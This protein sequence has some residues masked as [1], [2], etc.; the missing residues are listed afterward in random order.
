[1]LFVFVCIACQCLLPSQS[2]AG[3]NADAFVELSWSPDSTHADIPSVTPGS[4][5]YLYARFRRVVEF[6]TLTIRLRWFPAETENASVELTWQAPPEGA[7]GYYVYR[8]IAGNLNACDAMH[9]TVASTVVTSYTDV[10]APAGLTVSYRVAAFTSQGTSDPSAP[11]V[12]AVPRTVGVAHDGAAARTG[13]L[14]HGPSPA[15]A[16]AWFRFSVA[17]RARVEVSIYDVAGRR[18]SQ[19]VRGQLEPGTHVAGWE[20]A[21][22]GVR[23]GVYFASLI[24]D[25]RSVDRRTVVV[26][27]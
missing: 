13:F 14:D 5:I 24:V 11:T 17:G 2:Q 1:M 23:P 9:E 15:G 21:N 3:K 27:R 20:A 6:S 26:V 10:T 18:V 16:R 7:S 25:G 22:E 8:T 4:T 19:P 12:I